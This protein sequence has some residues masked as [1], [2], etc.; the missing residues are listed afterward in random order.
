VDA[1]DIDDR[2]LGAALHEM[3]EL[4]FDAE[5][6]AVEIDTGQ[7]PPMPECGE[8]HTGAR[9]THSIGYSPVTRCAPGMAAAFT[10]QSNRPSNFTVSCTADSTWA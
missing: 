9:S 3:I 7:L 8:L 4:S 2:A 6:D 1:R 5:E 10:A